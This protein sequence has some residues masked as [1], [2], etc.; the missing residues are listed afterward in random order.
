M[1]D[2][3]DMNAMMAIMR[4]VTAFSVLGIFATFT[5]SII[6]CIGACCDKESDV[7][8]YSC[9]DPCKTLT[10]LTIMQRA[11]LQA[12]ASISANAI[13]VL[14]CFSSSVTT[15]GGGGGTQREKTQ[16]VSHIWRRR[17]YNETAARIGT[18][19]HGGETQLCETK[20]KDRS[21]FIPGVGTEEIWVG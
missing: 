4:A 21:L 8:T 12:K 5:G 13:S 20:V 17:N 1:D 19:G 3:D 2:C 6:G 16:N 18:R 10:L 15:G 11:Y 9:L 7:R 14:C